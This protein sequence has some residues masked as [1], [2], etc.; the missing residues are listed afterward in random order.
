MRNKMKEN[1]GKVGTPGKRRW[2]ERQMFDMGLVFSSSSSLLP[3]PLIIS[4]LWSLLHEPYIAKSHIES[5]SMSPT[6]D[7]IY[8]I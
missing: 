8:S 6:L 3:D 7:Q 5:P 2:M 4:L 1:R